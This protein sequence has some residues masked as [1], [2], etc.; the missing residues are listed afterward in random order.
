MADVRVMKLVSSEEIIADFVREEDDCYVIRN[1]F[2]IAPSLTPNSKVSVF[3]WSIATAIPNDTE[4]KLGKQFVML[5]AKAP[6][7]LATSF[8][9]QTTGLT[10]PPAGLITG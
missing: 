8:I 10:V 9:G 4:H 7:S 5:M 6:D 2:C 1:P 3:P